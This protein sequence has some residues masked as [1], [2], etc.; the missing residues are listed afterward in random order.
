[1]K[2][3]FT[4]LAVALCST[5]AMAQVNQYFWAGGQFIM[6][7]PIG[8]IDSITFGQLDNTDSITLYLPHTIKVIHDTV[9]QKEYIYDT[10]YVTIHDTINPCAIPDG[11]IR[12]KFSVSDTKQ[13]YFSKG[14]LQYQASTDTWRFAENQYEYVGSNN[15][16]ISSS[17][18]G[19]IDLFGWGTGDNP[20]ISSTNP[21]DYSSFSEFGNNVILGASDGWY[22]MPKEEWIYLLQK[23][24]KANLLNFGC[25]INGQVGLMILPDDW[26][27]PKGITVT[28]DSLEYSSNTFTLED[29]KILEQ[30]GCAFLPAAGYRLGATDS[31]EN[32]TFGAYLTASP[33]SI[34]NRHSYELTFGTEY[35]TSYH[36]DSTNGTYS[37]RCVGRSVRLVHD[38]K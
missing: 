4:I 18:N 20:T 33:D 31:G 7:N 9:I 25:T 36:I 37:S 34:N 3:L 17:Y 10:M 23:R 5:L 38:V 35:S 22:T 26:V 15:Q 6:G 1:M 32:C 16:Y 30:H 14:N 29:W 12:G 11:A 8:Q 28:L 27:A 21:L 24:T 2:K 19:W 13:V